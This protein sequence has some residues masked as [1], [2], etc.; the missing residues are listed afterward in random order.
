M[1]VFDQQHRHIPGQPAYQEADALPFR[2]GQ[3]GERFVQQ[4][5]ARLCRQR[6]ADLHQ[7]LST[8][9]KAGDE[10]VFGVLEPEK[11]HK[12]PSFCV[13]LRQGAS[14]RPCIEAPRIARL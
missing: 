13:Y 3:A 6:H 12:F 4:Q 9:G 8:V 1:Y 5:D 11:F 10:C 7:P 2:R 14:A